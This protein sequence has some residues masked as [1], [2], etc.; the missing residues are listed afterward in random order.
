MEQA[1][2]KCVWI[3]NGPPRLPDSVVRR[4]A[5]S[6]GFPNLGRREREKIWRTSREALSGLGS[7]LLSDESLS[8]LAAGAQISPG[9]IAQTLRKSLEA[10]PGTEERLVSYVETQIAAHLRL[11]GERTEIPSAPPGYRPDCVNSSIPAA[12]MLSAL[13]EYFSARRPLPEKRRE[14][15]KLLFHGLPGRG[16]RSSPTGSRPPLASSWCGAASPT[17]S[18]PTSGWLKESSPSC[19]TGPRRWGGILLF[20]EV[21]SLLARRGERMQHY[22]TMLV[23]ELLHRLKGFTP[24][25]IGTTNRLG[26]ADPA[27]ARRFAFKVEFGTLLPEARIKMFDSIVRPLSGAELTEPE[28]RRLLSI[29]SLA[30]GD[31]AAAAAQARWR[32]GERSDNLSLLEMLAQEASFREAEA[33]GPESPDAKETRPGARPGA[34]N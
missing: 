17:C 30:P 10:G 31:F 33:A 24:V 13:E 1:G 19:S 27:A 29:P 22:T 21:D 15:L 32:R 2:S 28:R 5:F 11:S 18:R 4:F 6:L 16:R 9:V 8:R 12:G 23:N 26:S 20:D 3:V 14:G 34:V 7:S 25:F